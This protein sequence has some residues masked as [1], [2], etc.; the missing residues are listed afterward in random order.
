MHLPP[1]AKSMSINH[2]KYKLKK[3]LQEIESPMF[4]KN[5]HETVTLRIQIVLI[6]F[7]RQRGHV[8]H[9]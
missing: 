8:W 7:Y 3:L 5:G 2:L 1:L 6:K 9:V 4:L